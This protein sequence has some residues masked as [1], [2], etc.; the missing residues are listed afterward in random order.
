MWSNLKLRFKRWVCS[1][2]ER[3][4]RREYNK[5]FGS[6]VMAADGRVLERHIKFLGEPVAILEKYC[7]PRIVDERKGSDTS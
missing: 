2:R 1:R 5:R 6:P 4:R 7:Y 3:Q